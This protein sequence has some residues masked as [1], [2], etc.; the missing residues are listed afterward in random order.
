VAKVCATFPWWCQEEVYEHLQKQGVAL[1]R[2]QVRQAM[3]QSGWSTLRQELRQRYRWTKGSF[4]LREKWMVQELLRLVH[5]LQTCLETGQPLPAEEQVALADLQVLARE[6]GVELPP[7]PKAQPWLWQ[8]EK[9]LF[10]QW[11]AVQDDTVR[12]P[13]CGSTHVVRKSRKPRLKKYYGAKGN[14]QE[15]PVC[16]YYCR[17]HDCPRETF[18]HL[19]PGLVPYSRDR[20]DLH[21]CALQAYSWSYSTYRRV[22]QALQVSE[23]TVYRWVSAWGHEL[24]PV[25]AIFGL[26]RST[27]WSVSTRST[28]W[29]PKATNRKAR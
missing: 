18:T 9:V 10:G 3:E 19:P 13:A 5:Q 11:E 2:R 8:V 29:R 16:R 1:S 22:G 28:S 6:V 25:A 20:L 14:L 17:N 15:V 26:V 27:G 24:L 12:C 4:R 23:M 21:L 7:P